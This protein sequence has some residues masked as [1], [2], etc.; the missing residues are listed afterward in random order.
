MPISY[1][2]AWALMKEKGLTTTKI[3][4]EKIIGEYTLQ[5]M[6]TGKSVTLESLES[7]CKELNCQ[8]GDLVE[9]VREK[10]N[11]QNSNADSEVTCN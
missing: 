11:K 10:S 8:F 5:S 2:K 6:R 3:R 1:E 4:K 9:Y 7:L